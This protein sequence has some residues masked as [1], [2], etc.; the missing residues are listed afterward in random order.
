MD[1]N[2]TFLV[3]PD[4]APPDLVRCLDLGGYRWKTA[5]GAEAVRNSNESGETWTGAIV[6]ADVQPEAAWALCRELRRGDVATEP[7][8]VLISGAQ[9]DE[10]GSATVTW[11][12]RWPDLDT[13]NAREREEW[14]EKH[15]R[16]G[17]E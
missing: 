8:L 15:K 11:I 16:L 10:L 13:R 3:F 9:L 12:I 2:E 7:L 5:A 17:L 1:S 4:P 6:A 14:V